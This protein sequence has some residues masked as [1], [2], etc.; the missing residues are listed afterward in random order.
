MSYIHYG[1]TEFSMDKWE[2]IKNRQFFNKPIGGLWASAEDSNY[3]WKQW[4]EDESFRECNADN[5]FRFDLK[6][7][8]NVFTICNLN[9]V[10]KMPSQ[11]SNGIFM[12]PDF[13]EMKSS[14]IDV[15]DFR[16][17]DSPELYWALYGWDC[18]C[19]LVLNPD[20]IV[21]VIP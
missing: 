19:I 20:V 15:I 6:E 10:E 18:D 1:S 14:G 9:D 17:S 4:C 16:L 12:A 7:N 3:G 11:K 5:C 2:D 13:E 21:E 8:A